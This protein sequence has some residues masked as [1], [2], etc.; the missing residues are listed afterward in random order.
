MERSFQKP[1]KWRQLTLSK[2]WSDTATKKLVITNSAPCPV[3]ITATCFSDNTTTDDDYLIWVAIYAG[4]E[5]LIRDYQY[6]T[7]AGKYRIAA[8]CATGLWL[9]T[10]EISSYHQESWGA[11]GTGTRGYAG[12]NRTIEFLQNTSLEIRCRCTKTGTNALRFRIIFPSDVNV[13]EYSWGDA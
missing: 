11:A 12:Y 6:P 9:K 5:I 10:D 3:L 13:T 1:F 2:T 8:N 7:G 4:G